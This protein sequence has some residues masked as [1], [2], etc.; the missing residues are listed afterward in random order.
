MSCLL[1]G[2]VSQ[3]G[4]RRTLS[5]KR[6]KNGVT[7]SWQTIWEGRRTRREAESRKPRLGLRYGWHLKVWS[8][9]STD[10]YGNETVLAIVARHTT[11]VGPSLPAPI[12]GCGKRDATSL[13]E[14]WWRGSVPGSATIRAVRYSKVLT[15]CS[16]NGRTAR[17][18]ATS[19]RDGRRTTRSEETTVLRRSRPD[20][21]RDGGL[22]SKDAWSQG[23]DD[24][25]RVEEGSR[26]ETA[27]PEARES[28]TRCFRARGSCAIG[29]GT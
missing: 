16:E 1:K 18:R 7:V 29:S 15:V 2:G 23:L 14:G 9:L 12:G 26:A 17:E 11:A 28:T 27:F 25:L 20:V 22:V 13:W 6:M 4:C 19:F 24:A 3:R 8:C 21:M 10:S 5:T